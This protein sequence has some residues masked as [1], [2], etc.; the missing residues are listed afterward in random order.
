MWSILPW[1]LFSLGCLIRWTGY[2]GHLFRCVLALRQRP[3]LYRLKLQPSVVTVC[4]HCAK[5]EERS[6]AESLCV[7]REVSC[8]GSGQQIEKGPYRAEYKFNFKPRDP[9]EFLHNVE[10]VENEKDA[11]EPE[12]AHGHGIE[13]S[14]PAVTAVYRHRYAYKS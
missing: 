1:A 4:H 10:Q 14:S 9:G 8:Q 7:T 13:P 12:A 6:N 2:S 11:R 5:S 3:A